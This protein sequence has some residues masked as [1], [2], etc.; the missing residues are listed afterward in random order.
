MLMP[1]ACTRDGS[2]LTEPV[3]RTDSAEAATV[4]DP[5]AA[6]TVP[7]SS[8]GEPTTIATTSPTSPVT[9]PDPTTVRETTAPIVEVPETGVPGLD[10]DDA[11]CAAWSRFGGSWQVLSVGSSFLG[12][13]ERVATWEL[14]AAPVIDPAYAELIANFPDELAS[15]ADIV[16]DGYFGALQRRSADALASLGAAGV[17]SAMAQRLGSEWLQA[18]ARRDPLDPDLAFEVPEDLGDVVDLAADDFRAKRVEFH[19]DPSMVIGVDTPLTDAFLETACPDQ[20]TLTGQ[21]V[22]DG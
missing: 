14:A 20:G 9:T 4:S 19:L 1:A 7:V 6:A 16:A 13:P 3:D 8:G 2:N 12:D 18:L 5:M 17:T 22:E 15:E 11:F 21:E 10:S